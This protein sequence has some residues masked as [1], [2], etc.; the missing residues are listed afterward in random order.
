MPMNRILQYLP[1]PCCRAERQAAKWGAVAEQLETTIGAN[2]IEVIYPGSA[3][4]LGE[5]D[6]EICLNFWLLR[7][8]QIEPV[9]SLPEASEHV[10]SELRRVSDL[11]AAA[12]DRLKGGAA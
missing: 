2:L 7:D 11:L 6:N 9:Y 8:S 3:T 5:D 4:F 10:I 1:C 12:A